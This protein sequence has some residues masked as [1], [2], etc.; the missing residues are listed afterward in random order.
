TAGFTGLTF[1][2]MW[3]YPYLTVG[4]GLSRPAASAVMTVLVVVAVG[5][6][7]LIGALTQG[8]PLR[9]PTLVLIIVAVIGAPLLALVLWP[10]PAPMWL[11]TVLVFGF[12][13]GAPGSNI[14]FDFPR[15]DLG[16]H[17][18]GTATGVVILGGFIG[19]LTAILLIGVV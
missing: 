16:R 18:L 5:G 12:S 10:G 7:P 4:E 8:H 9:R 14:G 6:G 15:S 11:L 2:M 13:I 17:R 3:G 1:S 19:S